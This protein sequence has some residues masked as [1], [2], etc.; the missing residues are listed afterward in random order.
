MLADRRTTFTRYGWAKS[1][2][3]L[4]WLNNVLAAGHPGGD[5]TIIANLLV[6][7]SRWLGEGDLILISV[8]FIASRR[9]SN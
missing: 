3:E 7:S 2:Y 9:H 1:W 6:A 5:G 8:S 4:S